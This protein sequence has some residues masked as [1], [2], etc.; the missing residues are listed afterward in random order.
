MDIKELLE[1]LHKAST[2]ESQCSSSSH[3]ADDAEIDELMQQRRAH[4]ARRQEIE[5]QILSL[6]NK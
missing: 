1:S 6:L 2:A 4:K 5:N 3:N